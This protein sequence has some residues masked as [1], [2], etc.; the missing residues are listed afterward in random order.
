MA[1][2]TVFACEACGYETLKWMG[3]CPKCGA[4]DTIR[5]FRIEKD[6]PQSHEAPVL[7]SD[8]DLPEERIVLAIEE[9]DRV[10]GG[11]I[12]CG[13]SILLGGDPGIG[14]TTLCF[15]IASRM[16]ELGY[17]TLYVSGEESLR[18]LSSRKKRLNLAG[19]FPILTTNHLE[20]ILRAVAEK[21]YKLVIVDS[22]QS[23][24]NSRLP[25]LPGSVSQIK[26]VSS[27]LI[28]EMKKS[29][30]AHIFIGHVTKEGAIAG[31]KILEHLVDTVL[32]FE[33]D[34]MLPYRMLRAIKNRFGPVDEVGIFQMRREGLI[35]VENPSEFFV[36]ERGDIA[37]GS[38]LFPYV[39]GSRPIVLEVQAITPKSAFSMPKRLSLGYDLNRLFIL[40][41]VMEKMLGKPL[42]DRDVYVNVT[43]GMKVSEPAIDLAVAASILSSYRD[44]NMGKHTAFFGEIG[45]TGEI[46]KIVNMEARLKECERLGITRVFCPRGVEKIGSPETI[47]LKT[48]RDLYEHVDEGSDHLR[49]R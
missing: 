38:S 19:S 39:T 7:V 48:I 45:L 31:P 14:K 41:A 30:T 32:Y 34:K 49:T 37:S 15:A 27:R 17:D 9:M 46:R 1:K 35:S 10:L 13:S 28:M 8:E 26:D 4:W 12:T 18:Q 42:F 29:E 47:P 36:S 24:Y 43:G 25:M 11:G 44:I 40:I 20:D 3:R 33:G 21:N 6:M 5:E 22:I 23:T 16:V 2:K